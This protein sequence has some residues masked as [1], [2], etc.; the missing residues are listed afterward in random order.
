MENINIKML[1]IREDLTQEEMAKIVGCSK[2]SY[3]Q[4]EK[5]R[6]DFSKNE[7]KKTKAYFNLT[8]AEFWSIFFE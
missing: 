8:F 7:M 2:N 3:I 5:G 4:K 1:R 6:I